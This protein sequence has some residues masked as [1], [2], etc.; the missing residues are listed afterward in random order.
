METVDVGQLFVVRL[1]LARLAGR[2]SRPPSVRT[3][4]VQLKTVDA[5]LIENKRIYDVVVKKLVG[6]KDVTGSNPAI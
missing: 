3:L 5:F 1:L 2:S 4:P 6:E